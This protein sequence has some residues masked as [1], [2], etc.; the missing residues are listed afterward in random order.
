MES[1]KDHKDERGKALEMR[2]MAC[3]TFAETNKRH[4]DQSDVDD[5]GKPAGSGSKEEDR[6][7]S[8]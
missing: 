1:E 6:L 8:I 3:E 5:P 2:K 4:I 7:G